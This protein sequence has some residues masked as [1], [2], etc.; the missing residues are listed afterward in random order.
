[1]DPSETIR[2]RLRELLSERCALDVLDA[3]ESAPALEL[4]STAR[5]D[6]VLFDIAI[7]SPTAGHREGMALLSEF[8]R[9]AP[10]ALLIVLTNHSSEAYRRACLLAG[11]HH[12]FDKSL[13]F[14][15]A[16]EV[17]LE[18]AATGAGG[19]ARGGRRTK[20]HAS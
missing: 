18:V 10:S 17:T 7:E 4:I 11:A 20:T 15:S 1:M 19:G 9:L 6:V 16:V 12:F 3:G 8:K 5:V 2:R 13:E 14:E